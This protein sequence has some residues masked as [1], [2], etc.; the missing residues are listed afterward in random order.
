MRQLVAEA[1]VVEEGHEHKRSVAPA[2][3]ACEISAPF[4]VPVLPEVKLMSAGAPGVISIGSRAAGAACQIELGPGS[5]L[6][7]IRR[8]EASASDPIASEHC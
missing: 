5:P 1:G 6:S 2:G 8:R 4:E 3:A 7:M